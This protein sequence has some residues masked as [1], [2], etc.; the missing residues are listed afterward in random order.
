MLENV[1][2]ISYTSILQHSVNNSVKKI[3]VEDHY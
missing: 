3:A 1:F 2:T